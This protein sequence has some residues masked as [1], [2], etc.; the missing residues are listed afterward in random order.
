MKWQQPSENVKPSMATHFP[1]L[2]KEQDLHHNIYMFTT[3]IW[4]SIMPIGG[5]ADKQP[6]FSV[7]LEGENLEC[8]KAKI[9]M[10]SLCQ[11]N[12]TDIP[13][14]LCDA[15]SQIARHLS[16]DGQ[17]FYEIIKDDNEIHVN[18]F[19]SINI[20]RIFSWYLQIIPEGDRYS[21]KRK[22]TLIN[23]KKIWN[24]QIPSRL[25]GKREF[26]KIIKTLK[27]KSSMPKFYEQDIV[28]GKISKDYNFSKYIKNSEI[29]INKITNKWGWN[30][31]DLSAEKCTEFYMVYKMLIFIRAQAVFREHII[32]EI[33]QLMNRLSIDCKIIVTG[34]PTADEILQARIDMEN[35]TIDFKEALDKVAL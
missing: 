22:Y 17:G 4:Q 1:S 32:N 34:L 20:F 18:G 8:E 19:T 24:I 23:K 13:E 3:D 14:I 2:S 27:T 9:I 5:W 26:K 28:H 30:R 7:N 31:R 6:D 25:G 11:H 15:V 12:R 16:I 10:R 21:W 29:Y 35:G 33:N